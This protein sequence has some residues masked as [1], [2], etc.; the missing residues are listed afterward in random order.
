[1]MLVNQMAGCDDVLCEDDH[2]PFFH[3]HAPKRPKEN[4]G[5]SGLIPVV[6]KSKVDTQP[7]Y[8][9]VHDDRAQGSDL[10]SPSATS[11]PQPSCEGWSIGPVGSPEAKDRHFIY[12]RMQTG[13]AV[14]FS[15]ISA[16]KSLTVLLHP[17][18]TLRSDY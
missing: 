10:F 5:Q 4:S 14:I 16:S 15:L 1:M 11:L 6:P 8:P 13:L 18:Q 12:F 7:A 2:E 9:P 17:S 3:L